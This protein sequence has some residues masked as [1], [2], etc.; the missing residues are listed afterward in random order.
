[1]RNGDLV[2]ERGGAQPFARDEALENCRP[3]DALV[4]LEEQAGLF[5]GAFLAGGRHIEQDV[6]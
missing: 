4:V 3:G 1:M 5:E 2:P 6:R